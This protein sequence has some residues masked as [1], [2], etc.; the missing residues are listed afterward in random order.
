MKK[1]TIYL[2]Q[3]QC[4]CGVADQAACSQLGILQPRIGT[5]NLGAAF[6]V[7]CPAHKNLAG[8]TVLDSGTGF[9]SLCNQ[10]GDPLYLGATLVPQKVVDQKPYPLSV[11]PIGRSN[12]RMTLFYTVTSVNVNLLS[13]T[14]DFASES[15]ILSIELF[16]SLFRLTRNYFRDV[17]T[18]I[19]SS[20]RDR[21]GSNAVESSQEDLQSDLQPDPQE[22]VSGD[23]QDPVQNGNA[24]PEQPGNSDDSSN[25]PN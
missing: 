17:F 20:I 21:F 8:H 5:R 13:L 1:F 22:N 14:L 11:T 19:S 18:F 15:R 25:P 3:L 9:L 6:K 4:R 10:A 12:C 24:E 23:L 7:A 2:N 16:Q